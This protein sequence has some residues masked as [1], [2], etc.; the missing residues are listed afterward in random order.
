[1]LQ[2]HPLHTVAQV[3]CYA[4]SFYKSNIAF[5][6]GQVGRSVFDCYVFQCHQEVRFIHCSS[7]HELC[8]CTCTRRQRADAASCTLPVFNCMC[9]ARVLSDRSSRHM[10]RSEKC[11][12]AD[13]QQINSFYVQCNILMMPISYSLTC[14]VLNA[15]VC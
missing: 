7:P 13:I 10:Q 12:R 1:M 9:V 8:T 14:R 15:F 3:V 5:K 6:I 11:V 2:R 4:D